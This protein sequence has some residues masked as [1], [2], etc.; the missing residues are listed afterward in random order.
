MDAADLA[1][2]G[3][4]G[5]DRNWD[6]ESRGVLSGDAVGSRVVSSAFTD[7][8][9]PGPNGGSSDMDG[10][11][12][13]RS[14]LMQAVRSLNQARFSAHVS[15]CISNA[16]SGEQRYKAV[17]G[18]TT[19]LDAFR[20]KRGDGV[21]GAGANNSS[22]SESAPEFASVTSMSRKSIQRADLCTAGFVL[23]GA[24][25]VLENGFKRDGADVEACSSL[26][27]K[28]SVNR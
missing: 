26:C 12:S 25:E 24:D 27:S 1:A 14:N 8:V 23:T 10:S 13:A 16:T 28:P 20:P 17:V 6:W 3:E 2:T 22:E 21:K 18:G 11:L 19:T 9:G 7:T 4:G 15:K 5:M